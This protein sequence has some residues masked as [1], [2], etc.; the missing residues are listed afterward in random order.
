MLDK[1]KLD[2]LRLFVETQAEMCLS[3]ID[4]MLAETETE[5]VFEE[6]IHKCPKCGES[7]VEK[8]EE[9]TDLADSPLTRLTCLSCGKSW[10]PDTVEV[11]ING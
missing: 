10:H 7:V 6:G 9:T 8:I 5:P 2:K 4:G 3:M 11:P 1:E